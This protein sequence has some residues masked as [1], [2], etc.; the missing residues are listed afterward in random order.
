M[1]F[2]VIGYLFRIRKDELEYG[3]VNA[4][5]SSEALDKVDKTMCYDYYAYPFN[6]EG[7]DYLK[8]EGSIEIQLKND[9]E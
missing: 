1:R 7:Y 5:S 6:Q 9:I 3:I 8:S 4:N 2:L